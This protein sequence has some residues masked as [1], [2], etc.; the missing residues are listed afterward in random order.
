MIIQQIPDI[1][2]SLVKILISKYKG[3]FVLNSSKLHIWEHGQCLPH[4]CFPE[5][6]P[7]GTQ[8]KTLD[9]IENGIGECSGWYPGSYISPHTS[10]WD[11]EKRAVCFSIF[12]Y[13]SFSIFKKKEGGVGGLERSLVVLSF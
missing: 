9:G 11:T 7:A 12:L 13:L 10:G 6:F 2:P 3:I 4:L 1:K 5:C 8:W